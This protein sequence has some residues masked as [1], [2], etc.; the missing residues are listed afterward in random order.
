MKR[1]KRTVI[2]AHEELTPLTERI[3]SQMGKDG[4]VIRKRLKSFYRERAMLKDSPYDQSLEGHA[5]EAT[6]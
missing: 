2:L 4:A 6:N 5:M 1:N 3:L